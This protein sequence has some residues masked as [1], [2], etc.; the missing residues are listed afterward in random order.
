MK[1]VTLNIFKTGWE[2]AKEQ[3]KLFIV[4]RLVIE[5][6]LAKCIKVT[7]I[8]SD[9]LSGRRLKPYHTAEFFGSDPC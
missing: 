8:I 2:H 4:V 7:E 3:F 1:N 9:K 6:C 5:P